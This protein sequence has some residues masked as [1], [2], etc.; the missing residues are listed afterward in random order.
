MGDFMK[1]QIYKKENLTSWVSKEENG[2]SFEEIESRKHVI[3]KLRDYIKMCEVSKGLNA[4][5]IIGE[6]GQGKT[7]LYNGFIR[8]ELEEKGY[9]AFFVSAST[10]SNILKTKEMINVIERSSLSSVRI[11]STIFE[12]VNAENEIGLPSIKSY[13]FPEDYLEDALD[14]ILGDYNG[15]QRI[16]IFIDEFE[17]LLNTPE[18]LKSM[19][20][21]IK[22][23]INGSYKKIDANGDFSGSVHLFISLTPDA[24]YRLETDEELSLIAGGYERRVHEVELSTIR[25]QESIEFLRNLIKRLYD[26]SEPTP[27]PL[28]DSGIFDTLHR[29][30]LGNLGNL[31]KLFIELFTKFANYDEDFFEV[32]EYDHF[33]DFLQETRI[34]VFG[35]QT[36]CV[37]VE[38]YKNILRYLKDTSEVSKD[39]IKSLI[40]LFNILIA[41]MRPI[42][43]GDL[44]K[45]IDSEEARV[46]KFIRIIN[47]KVENEHGIDNAIIPVFPLKE[48]LSFEDIK[49]K[50]SDYI[51]TDDILQKEVLQIGDYSEP[52]DQFE[53]SITFFEGNSDALNTR[54]FIPTTSESLKELFKNE[55]NE[56]YL[57]EIEALFR[58]MVDESERYYIISNTFAEILYPTP[59][60]RFLGYILKKEER[61]SIWRRISLNLA[62]EYK[63]NI[64]SA[65]IEG[66]E[67]YKKL[68]VT[69]KKVEVT[70]S[71]LRENEVVLKLHDPDLEVDIR[72]LTKFVQGDIKETHIKEISETLKNDFSVHG[73]LLVYNGEFTQRARERLELEGLGK[74][75]TSQLIDIHLHQTLTKRLLCAYES[76]NK[77]VDKSL[78]N[79]EFK[80]IF[81]DLKLQENIREWLKIQKKKGL[82]VDQVATE[83]LSKFADTLKL[84]LNYINEPLSANE[85][86]EKNLNGILKFKLYGTKKGFIKSDLEDSPEDVKKIS[87][88]L[89]EHGFLEE[90]D[91]KYKVIEHPVERRI[92]EI[93]KK[94]GKIKENDLNLYF[95][96]K[97]K[98]KNIFSDLFLNILEYK[99]K[100]KRNRDEIEITNIEAEYKEILKQL[101]RFNKDLERKELYK[102]FGHIFI[103][104]KRG[105]KLIMLDE[106]TSFV[107]ENS[108]FIK[109]YYGHPDYKEAV[110]T[111][112]FICKKLLTEIF[113]CGKKQR[114][115]KTFFEGAA[116]KSKESF[117]EIKKIK[118]DFERSLETISKD[119]ENILKLK[120]DGGVKSIKEYT[121]MLN[122]FEGIKKLY[123]SPCTKEELENAISNLDDFDHFKFDKSPSTAYYYNLKFYKI[124]QK[125]LEFNSRRQGSFLKDLDID[126]L[127]KRR[128]KVASKLKSIQIDPRLKLT[129][130]FFEEI[131]SISINVT[132]K[133][134][135]PI[136]L[137][138][139]R[140]QIKER[141][142]ELKDKLEKVDRLLNYLNDLMNKEKMLLNTIGHTQG[143]LDI[144]DKI[145]DDG[146]LEKT[147]LNKYKDKFNSVKESYENLRFQDLRDYQR[148]HGNWLE[149]LDNLN[150]DLNYDINKPIKEIWRNYRK[151]QLEFI[152]DYENVLE[153]VKISDDSRAA[154]DALIKE[155]GSKLKKDI[156]EQEVS[157]SQIDDLKLK[158]KREFEYQMKDD[159]STDELS[160]LKTINSLS[161]AGIIDY[162]KLKKRALKENIDFKKAQ[163]GLIKKGYVKL[164]FYFP[165]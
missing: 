118:N 130:E 80:S 17:E 67:T 13:E 75:G 162:E 119:C 122:D 83:N 164:G 134:I 159:L 93:I 116:R 8:K 109:E 91:G 50:L 120:I 55:V 157:A 19:I 65:F 38:N 25:K 108:D 92:Y 48:H 90:L 147:K 20:S 76:R 78:L 6:W 104:K 132:E 97:S 35:A 111:K 30:S 58:D 158:I 23:L 62:E 57:N 41:Y 45:F 49:E 96:L 85:V 4:C 37:D 114:C 105:H 143:I 24:K 161:E 155:F 61:L 77:S 139:L 40:N 107:N 46:Y 103:T 5:N 68:K 21:G 144:S 115:L 151:Q 39:K 153:L 137:K 33:I 27:Y 59:I 123:D 135:S 136:S 128:N 1:T 113:S 126:E 149:L 79:I 138:E 16:F 124:K 141:I 110:S 31:K 84:Y 64:E 106:F 150:H 60:P 101:D 102:L 125:E 34:Y 47:E 81:D 63:N 121:N 89:R 12:G 29:L 165:S 71:D 72:L 160:L 56:D 22:E 99:N 44:S 112:I 28:G 43:I 133:K 36:L 88:E 26:G 69:Y 15:S 2:T 154:L 95:I 98:S 148:E 100:I 156:T 9:M 52:L 140:D 163:E 86:L 11:L 142:K 94:E 87:I 3:N 127:K 145:F 129:T 73:C 74:K 70:G 18:T 131:K 146:K 117:H 32:V 51:K 14:F 82:V 7:E 10:L 42:S 152:K 54:I 66:L 53:D